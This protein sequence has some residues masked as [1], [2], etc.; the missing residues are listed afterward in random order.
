[1]KEEPYPDGPKTAQGANTLRIKDVPESRGQTH[2]VLHVEARIGSRSSTS[3]VREK[4]QSATHRFLASQRRVSAASYCGSASIQM[5]YW[6]S[7]KRENEVYGL[8]SRRV[9]VS[10]SLQRSAASS[11]SG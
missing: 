5:Y 7:N 1:V 2:C 4:E 8:K 6:I 3:P 10:M 9:Q 11:M